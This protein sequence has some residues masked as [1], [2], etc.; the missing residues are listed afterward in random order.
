MGLG[1]I[2]SSVLKT[3][4]A[5]LI[6][7]DPTKNYIRFKFRGQIG[8]KKNYTIKRRY[9]LI[10]KLEKRVI[11]FGE[12]VRQKRLLAVPLV[13]EDIL[14]ALIVKRDAKHIGFDAFDQESLLVLAEQLVMAL[15]NMRLHE[16]HQKLIWGTVKSL[17]K[18]LDS[19]VP[20]LYSHSPNF[21]RLVVGIA[22]ELGLKEAELKSLEYASLLHDTGKIDIPIDIL[23]K[24]ARL[25]GKEFSIIRRHP[26][27]GVEL[28]RHL[29]VLKP[30]IPII[31]HHHERYDGTGYP[32]GL[33]KNK[34]PLG[35]RIMAIADAFEAMVFGRPYRQRVSIE[36]AL[37][38]IKRKSGTQFDPK[39]VET[40]LRVVKTKLKKYLKY[41]Q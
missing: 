35:A 41:Y 37:E 4:E 23:T 24:P 13:S 29:E 16:E 30:V 34:I 25:T 14:G 21:M 12:T 39:I 36:K 33:K 1:R 5:I 3:T 31:L 10:S 8:A 11:Q 19:K 9:K 15:H 17:V 2:V 20:F 40:F 22:E 27:K 7:T 18:L 6:F 26:L 38:E 32:S 28:V